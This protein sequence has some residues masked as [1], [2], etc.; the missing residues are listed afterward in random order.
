MKLNISFNVKKNTSKGNGYWKFDILPTLTLC[1]IDCCN[2]AR[3]Y[4]MV[5]WLLWDATLRIDVAKK[6]GRG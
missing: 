4:A 2:E 3:Y 1:R 6:G 5:G